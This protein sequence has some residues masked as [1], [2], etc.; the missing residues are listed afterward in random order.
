LHESRA[1]LRAYAELFGY[2]TSRNE[3]VSSSVIFPNHVLPFLNAQM[4]TFG[5]HE[6]FPALLGVLVKSADFYAS[7]GAP[8]MFHDSEPFALFLVAL[9][10]GEDGAKHGKKP[11]RKSKV[12]FDDEEIIES[13]KPVVVGEFFF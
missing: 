7:F 1:I 11:R 5:P 9:C 10:R 8:S 13:D 2:M 6:E 4:E 12:H 3:S